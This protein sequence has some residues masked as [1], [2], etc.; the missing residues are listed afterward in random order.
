MF[1]RTAV[2]ASSG[3]PGLARAASQWA[4]ARL[5]E[6]AVVQVAGQEAPDLLQ[7]LM[8]NDISSLVEGERRSMYCMFLN[9]AGRVLFDAIIHR[10]GADREFLLDL[11]REVA[12][13][14]RQHLS[15]YRLRRKVAIT[16]ADSLS[17]H[18]VFQ[19]AAAASPA[20]AQP[21]TLLGSTFCGPGEGGAA[22]TGV[23][24]GGVGGP[25][26]RLADL[27]Y[28]LVL[29]EG[30]DATLHLP[31]STCPA[32]PEDWIQHRLRL[33][34][35]EGAA[36]IPRGKATPLEYNL[37]YLHGVSFHKGCYIGQELTAR[38]HHTGVVRKRVVP[39]HF[40]QDL[41]STGEAELVVRTEAGKSVGKVRRVAGGR[42]LGLLRLKESL[43]AEQLSVDSTPLSVSIPAWWPADKH[44]NVSAS[45]T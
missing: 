38:T 2:R 39:L 31:E 20:P 43:A 24:G 40:G 10:G 41:P 28:R 29:G 13:L 4:H 19:P 8:T 22:D 36:D 26:P 6:R 18:C 30:E 35:A 27:G 12:A 32:T 44:N 42:G 9:T 21:N 7:G 25:D 23:A 14:A 11:D 45:N 37:D 3:V 16:L 5:G 15:L 17:V 33:G 34:V 1:H